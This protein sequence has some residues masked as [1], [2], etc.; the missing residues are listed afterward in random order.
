MRATSASLT[1]TFS[2]LFF[3]NKV[4]EQLQSRYGRDQ[5]YTYVG[6]ILIAVNPFHKMDIYTPQ[7]WV[8]TPL[9]GPSVCPVCLTP[10]PPLLLYFP[11]Y[12]AVHRRQA[13]GSPAAHL[14]G[15][16]RG[17]PVHGVLQRRPGEALVSRLGRPGAAVC[18]LCAPPRV[19][20][21]VISGESGA[22]KTENA[23]LLVQQLTVLGKVS[24]R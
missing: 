19:Q 7:V 8:S 3:Q 17:L 18:H 9:W 13:H 6:D 16:R 20:C 22:G 21:V 2:W 10:P 11:A 14:C 15:G 24:Q 1:K 23:H 5:I 12:Q 4:T